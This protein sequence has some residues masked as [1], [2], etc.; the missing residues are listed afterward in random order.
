MQSPKSPQAKAPQTPTAQGPLLPSVQSLAQAMRGGEWH[1]QW[2]H[3]SDHPLL[4]WITRGQGRALVQGVRTGVGGHNA[5]FVP[6]GCLHALDLS[7]QSIGLVLRFPA[8][9]AGFDQC[10]Q[11]L[12]KTPCHLRISDVA[13]QGE[14][15][16]LLDALAREQASPNP[17]KE[18]AMQAWATLAAL[19]LARHQPTDS[20]R[21][22]A[23]QRLVREFCRLLAQQTNGSQSMADFAAQLGVTP[24]HLT[25]CCKQ[26]AG[27]TAAEMQTQAALYAARQ[28]IETTETTLQT[29]GQ[30]LGFSSAAYFSRFIQNHTGHSPSMLRKNAPNRAAQAA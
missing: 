14:L 21:Q 18:P 9:G 4:Y 7:K 29:I 15:T 1:L 27:M 19:W 11:H 28:M 13:K 2:L 26:I 17:L 23:A 25:R 8:Q 24:T 5:V 16:A 6:A 30:Q 3:C 10:A 12:P 22:P 20:P